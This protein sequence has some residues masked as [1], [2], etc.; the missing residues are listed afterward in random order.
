MRSAKLLDEEQNLLKEVKYN[1]HREATLE[2]GKDAATT[3][4]DT[5]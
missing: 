4:K 1:K 2:L 3:E 5:K